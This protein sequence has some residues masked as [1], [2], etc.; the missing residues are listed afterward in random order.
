[1]WPAKSVNSR[2]APIP[3]TDASDE[4]ETDENGKSKKMAAS[5][6]LDRHQPVEQMTWAPGKPML[7]RGRL[8]DDGGW[9]EHG[10]ATTFNPA[11]AEPGWKSRC[12]R[13][14]GQAH[15]PCFRRRR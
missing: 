6:W 15:P 13:S 2:I 9:I 7:I 5:A 11:A 1:M 14:V 8:I 12:G 10:G 4:A 3:I